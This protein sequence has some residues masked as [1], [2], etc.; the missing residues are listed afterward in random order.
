MSNKS[1]DNESG[2]VDEAR[3][4]E[5]QRAEIAWFN[6]NMEAMREESAWMQDYKPFKEQHRITIG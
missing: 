6:R 1:E 4:R 5:A 3:L 2:H